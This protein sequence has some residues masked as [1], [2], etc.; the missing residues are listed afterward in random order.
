MISSDY[1][2]N[3]NKNIA[4]RPLPGDYCVGMYTED[5]RWYRARLIRYISGSSISMSTWFIRCDT[6]NCSWIDQICEVFYIDYGNLEE[7]PVEF[8][9]ELTPDFVQ[10][11]ARAIACTI[12]EVRDMMTA[13]HE[14]VS[15]T[16]RSYLQSVKMVGQN[17]QHLRLHHTAVTNVYKP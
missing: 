5:A 15:W 2:S 9:H 8:L 11:P 4:Y 6:I 12:A 13:M 10:L 1:Y 3:L 17:V 14:Y 16:N 7:L